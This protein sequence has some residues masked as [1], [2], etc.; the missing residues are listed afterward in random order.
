MTSLYLLHESATGYVLFDC[1]GLDSVGTDLAAVQQSILDVSRFGAIMKLAAFQPFKSAAE[2]L[3]EINS[4]SE[5]LLTEELQQFLL[6]S[7]PKVCTRSHS[8]SSPIPISWM[9]TSLISAFWPS[10]ARAS[11]RQIWVG[12]PCMFLNAVLEELYYWWFALIVI[13]IVTLYPVYSPL[14]IRTQ[15]GCLYQ[16]DVQIAVNLT[17]FCNLEMQLNKMLN[18]I[19]NFTGASFIFINWGTSWPL[20]CLEIFR[21]CKICSWVSIVNLQTCFRNTCRPVKHCFVAGVTLSHW[22]DDYNKRY[23]AD[24]KR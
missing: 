21:T 14:A 23:A 13:S 9:S 1:A 11:C 18:I 20:I 24:Q 16:R 7:L 5:G 22:E 8:C 12:K 17:C 4:I 10:L 15:M 6:R 3:G 19:K 2:A